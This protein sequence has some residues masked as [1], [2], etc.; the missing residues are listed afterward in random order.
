MSIASALPAES[1]SAVSTTAA[2]RTMSTGRSRMAAWQ[3]LCRPR[4]AVMSAIA[5]AVGYTLSSVNGVHWPTL[6]VSVLG[7]VSF[8]AA[9]SIFNQVLERDTDARMPRTWN[10]PLVSGSTTIAEALLLGTAC[11]VAG[12]LLLGVFVNVTTSLAS[13][14][15]MLVYVLVYTPLKPRSVLC[16]TI[17]AIPG[18]MPPVLGWLAAGGPF[19]IEMCAL[20]AVFFVWQFPH[21]LAI[22]WIYRDQYRHAG[23]KMLPRTDDSGRSA[24]LIALIYAAAFLPVSCLPRYAGLAGDGYQAAACLLALGYL[25]LTLRFCLQR[26]DVRAKQLM[27]GSLICLPSLLICLLVDFLRLTS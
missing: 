6:L 19:G 25:I 18:A 17:G 11:A 24:G 13:F 26:T 8:V 7:I 10:R 22:A 4:I 20:F 5:A 15:T 2:N 14:L 9:S 1:V 27:L 21:F 3:Q 12:T 16:T 23:L